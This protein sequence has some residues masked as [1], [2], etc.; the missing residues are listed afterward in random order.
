MAAQASE[1]TARADQ[2]LNYIAV[3]KIVKKRNKWITTRLAADKDSF[4]HTFA[5]LHKRLD[6]VQILM[7]QPFYANCTYA[8]HSFCLFVSSAWN[9]IL[10]FANAGSSQT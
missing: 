6:A 10:V 7:Q 3:V 1:M 2:V 8:N 9:D 4:A 5:G